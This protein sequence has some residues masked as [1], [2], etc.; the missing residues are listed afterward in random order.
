MPS[1]PPNT[2]APLTPARRG[3]RVTITGRRDERL[4]ELAVELG[5]PASLL[6]VSGDAADYGDV[7]AAVQASVTGFGRQALGRTS[8]PAACGSRNFSAAAVRGFGHAVL[9]SLRLR[10]VPV[11][12]PGTA[13]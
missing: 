6:T 2:D 12:L 4:R 5:N 11:C 3:H 7:T 1:A 9:P 13:R 10:A 8:A